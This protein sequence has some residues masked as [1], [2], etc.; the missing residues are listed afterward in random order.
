MIKSLALTAAL[1]L[2]G[3]VQAQDNK[4]TFVG[5]GFSLTGTPHST[6]FKKITFKH[7]MIELDG[8]KFVIVTSSRY[9]DVGAVSLN[10]T[11]TNKRVLFLS[12]SFSVEEIV[13]AGNNPLFSAEAYSNCLQTPYN[14]VAIVYDITGHEVLDMKG[15]PIPLDNAIE[16]VEGGVNVSKILKKELFPALTQIDGNAKSSHGVCKVIAPK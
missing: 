14:A 16:F 15:N 9:G 3:S 5:E 11:E 13:V 1:L 10:Y 7:G 6:M 2:A 4:L 12:S 8:E